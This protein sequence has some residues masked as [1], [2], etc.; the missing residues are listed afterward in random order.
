MSAG[1]IQPTR[2]AALKA[3]AEAARERP[4]APAGVE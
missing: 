2:A 3:L 4:P 1:L